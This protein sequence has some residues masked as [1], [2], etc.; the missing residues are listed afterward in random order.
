MTTSAV[1]P[2]SEY[3]EGRICM[4][5]VDDTDLAPGPAEVLR[6][7]RETSRTGGTQPARGMV[8]SVRGQEHRRGSPGHPHRGLR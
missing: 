7:P 4:D 2:S 1:T 8:R 6:N 5:G 3:G